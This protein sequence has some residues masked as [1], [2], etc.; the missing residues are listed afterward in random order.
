MN[1]TAVSCLQSGEAQFARVAREDDAPSDADGH[2]GGGIS[3]ESTESLAQR[4]N[5]LGDRYGNRVG[6]ETELIELVALSQAHGLLFDDL[7]GTQ[8]GRRCIGRG[9]LTH[10]LKSTSEKK[11]QRCRAVGWNRPWRQ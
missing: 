9:L 2:T 1:S 8:F 3:F 5:C 10:E 6:L 7:V 4:G 11:R